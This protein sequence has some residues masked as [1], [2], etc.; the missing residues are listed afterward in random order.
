MKHKSISEAECLQ[1]LQ[2][3]QTPPHVIRHCAAVTAAALAI[4]KALNEKGFAFDLELIQG[5]G[6]MHDIARAGKKHW[7]VGAKIAARHGYVREAKI[8]RKHMKHALRTDPK[9]LTE[10]DMVCL[11][12]RLVLEDRYVGLERRMQYALDK[13]KGHRRAQR[14]ICAE[15]EAI[16]ALLQK[17]EAIIGMPVE[18]LLESDEIFV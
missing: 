14:A 16:H 2:E 15:K 10:L 18:A 1:L 5:A 4:A 17:L 12:D 8:I 11:G 3:H 6:L 9:R 7:L 13:S